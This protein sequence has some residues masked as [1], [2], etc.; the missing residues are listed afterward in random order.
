MSMIALMGALTLGGVTAGEAPYLVAWRPWYAV[1]GS[2]IVSGDLEA[3]QRT[4]NGAH[5]NK[6]PQPVETVEAL[7][8]RKLIAGALAMRFRPIKRGSRENSFA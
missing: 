3:R 2:I 8:M 5:T 4:P 6:E 1:C 7:L